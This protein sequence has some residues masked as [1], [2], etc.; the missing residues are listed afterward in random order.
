MTPVS[1]PVPRPAPL[2]SAAGLA[3]GPLVAL[4]FARFAYALVLPAMVRQLGWSL[5]TAGAMN[6]A[7]GL[8]YLLGAL[9]AAP[10]G[11]R[12]GLAHVFLV[13]LVVTV[14]AVLGT[15]ATSSTFVLAVARLVSGVG[16][17]VVFVVGGGLVAEASETDAP[18]RASV[19]LGTYFG[20]AGVGI[21]VSAWLVPRI[22]ATWAPDLA[23]RVAWKALGV[24]SVVA[25]AVAVP[26][27]RRLAALPRAREQRARAARGR[28]PLKMLRP[29]L[30]A[31]GAYGLG[32][33]VYMTFVVALLEHHG[34]GTLE[35]T[36]FWTA[37]GAAAALSAFL[38]GGV[39]GRAS[40][41]RGVA[42]AMLVVLAGTMLPLW[43]SAAIWALLSALLFGSAFL[44]VVT[45][46]TSV[47]RRNLPAEGWTAALG[48]LTV[49]FGVGQ[50]IGPVAAG[51]LAPTAGGIQG[52]LLVSA[53]VLALAAAIAW[54]QRDAG[55]A[56]PRP[57]D[58]ASD[59]LFEKGCNQ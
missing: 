33:I 53:L 58:R 55:P 49:M 14:V 4:G 37:L 30:V 1:G 8:G 42:A 29:L 22:L 21:V 27:V 54:A 20:G 40:G 31:Y 56:R 59:P 13:S 28:T 50:S 16:G 51:L 52:G 36:W 24:V 35:I 38:W 2:W 12:W 57:L 7:N 44:A 46:V 19:L 6:T 43:S 15:G 11:R 18:R 45:A 25:L 47:A 23:W 26:A 9:A 5:A 39:V 48:A 32:Y 3:A 17:G 34:A 41:G 10:L